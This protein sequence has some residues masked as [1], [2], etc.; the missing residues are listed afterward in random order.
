MLRSACH[1]L[2]SA[3]GT[4]GDLFQSQLLLRT[5]FI[6]WHSHCYTFKARASAASASAQA[7]QNGSQF[8][9][10]TE[11]YFARWLAGISGWLWLVGE[12]AA[13]AL[14]CLPPLFFQ[15]F[16]AVWFVAHHE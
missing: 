8:W 3:L 6:P 12:A 14:A 5:P 11:E 9:T 10:H 15:R 4:A 7:D 2:P 1:V 13:D 16:P